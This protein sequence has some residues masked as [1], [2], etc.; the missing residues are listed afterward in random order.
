MRLSVA[1]LRRR[2]KGKLP[3]EF[4]RQELTSYSG[5][6][7]LRR[8]LWQHDLPRRVRTACSGTG[9]DYGGGRLALLVLALLYVGA[10]R[11]EHLRYVAGD[12]LIARFCGLARIPTAR[13]VGNWLRQFTQNTL[14]PL[15]QLNHDLVIDAVRRLA[16]PRLTIDIDG[17]VVRTGATVS[18]AFRGFNPHH[19]KDPSYYPLLAH[20]AQT[21]HI[22]R[23]KNRPGNVP[24]SKQSGAFLREVIDGLRTAFGRR[25]PLE[26]RMDAAF[27][28]RDVL[29]LLAARGWAYAIKVGSWSGLPLKQLA[30]ERER[31]R[32]VAPNVTGFFHDLDIPQWH[33]RLRVMIYRK[34]V[35]HESPKNFQ[36][37]LFTPKGTFIERPLG[38]Y[39]TDV[40]AQNLVEV[41]STARAA[42]LN[43]LLVGDSHA[44]SA[45]YATV[46]Q[47]IPTLARLMA[48][49]GDMPVGVVLLAPFYHPILLAE[50]IG[51]LAAFTKAPLII[52]FALGARPR[53]FQAFGMDQKSRVGRLEET[54]PLVR[55]LLT[56]EAVSFK[57]RYWA[58][59]GVQISPVPRQPVSIWVAGTVRS[60]AER[61]GRLGDAWLTAQ[62]ASR[63]QLVE[64]LEA[65]HEAAV[66]AGRTPLPRCLRLRSRGANRDGP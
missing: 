54:V 21:G 30:A 55:R 65:Y 45:S 23:V 52:T 14:A 22:L 53:Q 18:W 7:L 15:V 38:A 47:P 48:V 17:P 42:G 56:G 49:T 46:F 62:N 44:A 35:G 36:L 11:L 4:V 26:V 27:F 8:Y 28:Q 19:R 61:A 9:R 57:G 64:Q 33:L 43:G 24:D 51:T 25:L 34:H 20:V 16:L 3:V 5:L 13:T 50:Q 32:P 31:W 63:D 66:S 60:S 41:A 58:L 29:R 6:E 59:E 1:S 10:R 39:E 2:I 12:P 37:D 40:Q